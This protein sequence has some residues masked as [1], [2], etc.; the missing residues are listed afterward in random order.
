MK[1]IFEAEYGSDLAEEIEKWIKQETITE[2]GG[3]KVYRPFAI[4]E[5]FDQNGE[6]VPTNKAAPRK[7]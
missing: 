7:I 6:P 2:E 5:L 1:K 4:V 3:V